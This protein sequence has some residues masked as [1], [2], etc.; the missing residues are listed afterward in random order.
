MRQ[1]WGWVLAGCL[2]FAGSVQANQTTPSDFLYQVAQEYLKTGQ[3]GEAMHELRKL[4]LLDPQHAQAQRTLATLE[5]AYQADRMQAMEEMLNRLSRAQTPGRDREEALAQAIRQAQPAQSSEPPAPRESLQE[6][7]KLPAIGGP[8]G[9]KPTIQSPE[10]TRREVLI[11]PSR[12]GFQKFYKEGIGFEP[13]PGLGI[14]G[15]TEIFEEPNPVEDYILESKILNFD[16][17]SQFRRS[18]VPLFTRSGAARI[19]ADYKPWPRFTYEYDARET[20]NEFTTRFGF[21]DIDRQTHAVNA[22]YSLP[23]VPWFGV[24]TVN[25]WYKRVLQSSDHD[26][27][28]YEHRDETILNFSLQQTDNVEYFFQFDGYEARKTRTLGGS[29]LKLYKGQVRLRF[30]AWRLFMIPSYEYSDTDFDPS[31]DEFTKRDIFVDWGLDLTDRLRAATKQ[32]FI[33]A[34]V[35]RAGNVPSNPDAEVFN[36]TNTFSYEL[37]KDF[38]VSLGV[39]WSKAFGYNEFNNVGFRAEMELFKAGLIRSK[40]GYEWLSY[41]NISDDLSLVYWK[42][43]LFQ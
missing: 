1:A 2:G 30:P 16:E 8:A 25:P 7:L 38:D 34:E 11:A 26:L 23:E 4:L 22:L 43:F 3:R 20:L 17:I 9:L 27:G 35:S 21:K 28:S 33:K 24:L 15:R 31:D 10:Q 12:A 39:D 18:I 32:Q 42:F 13:V 29:K 36:W 40:L 14:S 19:I 6:R 5:Q 41:Y 37:F